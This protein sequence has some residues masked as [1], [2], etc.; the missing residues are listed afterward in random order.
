MKI[1]LNKNRQTAII[2]TFAYLFLLLYSLLEELGLFGPDIGIVSTIQMSSFARAMF[3]DVGILATLCAFWILI[4]GK[5]KWRIIFAFAT[6]FVGSF[7]L[8]PY[9]IM[10][11][12]KKP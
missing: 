8:L 6:L 3:I 12:W 7:A 11:F 9:L 10:H 1:T 2:L 4:Y 5:E